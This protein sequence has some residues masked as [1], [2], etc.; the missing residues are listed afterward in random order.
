M[1]TGK[2]NPMPC[3]TVL[4]TLLSRVPMG[5]TVCTPDYL[6]MSRPLDIFSTK[7]DMLI[8]VVTPSH[9]AGSATGR[10]P[11][12]SGA[13][14]MPTVGRAL[15]PWGEREKR[16]SLSDH[17]RELGSPDLSSTTQGPLALRP[18]TGTAPR[19]C[20]PALPK[21]LSKPPHHTHPH[22]L[23]LDVLQLDG[24]LGMV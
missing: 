14:S 6:L 13:A 19:S 9:S 10:V 4:V 21:S 16:S 17:C 18:L 3:S 22:M 23:T 1:P 15:Y 20:A 2:D 11:A 12:A 24:G 7:E 5:D 8:R